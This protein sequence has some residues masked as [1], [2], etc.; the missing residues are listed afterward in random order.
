[1]DLISI[2][3]SR[4]LPFHLKNSLIRAAVQRGVFFEVMY[5]L[6]IS[7]LHA[8][9]DIFKQVQVLV[10]WTHGRSIIVSSGAPS[11][12]ELRGPNDV[13]NLSTLFGLSLEHAKAAISKNC[14]SLILRGVTRKNCYKMAIQVK[15]HAP[16]GI[17][18]SDKAWF[19]ASEVWDPISSGEG[20][21]VLK[22][23]LVASGKLNSE[24][25][26]SSRAKKRHR[27]S[28]KSVSISSSQNNSVLLH[29]KKAVVP[30]TSICGLRLKESE[31]SVETRITKN[32]NTNIMVSDF[33]T[34]IKE[35]NLGVEK[36]RLPQALRDGNNKS[37]FSSATE[38]LPLDDNT[39]QVMTNGIR[40][41]LL[42][43]DML[44]DGIAQVS[45]HQSSTNNNMQPS[46]VVNDGSNKFSF[47]SATEFLP[48]NDGSNQAT[49]NGIG[50]T[51]IQ[52]AGASVDDITDVTEYKSS[53][54]TNSQSCN[55]DIGPGKSADI[56]PSSSFFT[57]DKGLSVIVVHKDGLEVCKEPSLPTDDSRD[58]FFV[59]SDSICDNA[60]QMK[61]SGLK[62][63]GRTFEVAEEKAD[64]VVLGSDIEKNGLKF[65]GNEKHITKPNIDKGIL[66]SYDSLREPPML[67][68]VAEEE[69][70]SCVNDDE[71]NAI[72]GRERKLRKQKMDSIPGLSLQGI[73]K[74]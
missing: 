45:E 52:T 6:A 69:S 11:V 1:V 30:G 5:S 56:P 40:G 53:T 68:M 17:V 7:N 60:S 16:D 57:V 65:R 23:N 67:T 74:S 61:V 72:T 3:F 42:Q 29:Q 35:Q 38:F 10:E 63:R 9:R 25:G 41:T 55:A 14:R 36:I 27:R 58:I 46:V 19:N 34:L 64:T 18:G 50:G 54:N 21:V 22:E 28:G 20:D 47:S 26:H 33:V 48:F 73:L 15:S 37:S 70:V 8:R 66:V 4:K 62:P 2:D 31:L 12:N 44:V 24:N 71:L 43:N 39:Q 32:S 51:L 49:A 59:K 13:V